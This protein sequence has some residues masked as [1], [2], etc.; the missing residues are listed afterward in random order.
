MFASTG[1][2]ATSDG[3]IYLS[4]TNK[5]SEYTTS[6]AVAKDPLISGQPGALAI[7]NGNL[8]V[9]H[10]GNTG[11]GSVALCTLSG[12]LL[13]SSLIS[14]LDD[15]HA[16][17]ISGTDLYIANY[18]T[19]TIGKYTTAGQTINSVFISGLIHPTSIATFGGNLF[20][21][22][23]GSTFTSGTNGEYSSSGSPINPSLVTGLGFFP[24]SLVSDG[25]N[26]F[27]ACTGDS[28]VTEYTAS[29]TRLPWSLSFGN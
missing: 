21:T 15:P 16:I 4:S 8:Y 28:T 2:A 17:A 23:V 7:A 11:T 24:N 1:L 13:N 20:I 22:T 3:F 6:G 10:G 26:L 29:G 18:Q 19:G 25:S 5:I 27:V 12:T 9:T 14:G